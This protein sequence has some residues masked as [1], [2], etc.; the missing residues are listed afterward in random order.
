MIQRKAGISKMNSH[1]TI[2]PLHY[3]ITFF[4]IAMGVAIIWKY[5][6]SPPV[7]ISISASTQKIVE[8]NYSQYAK[9]SYVD[10]GKEQE[11]ICEFRN[12]IA[13]QQTDEIDDPL[14]R[15]LADFLA[16]VLLSKGAGDF[17]RYKQCI[18]LNTRLIPSNDVEYFYQTWFHREPPTVKNAYELAQ[19]MY[20]LE[21]QYN[22]GKHLPVACSFEK[23]AIRMRCIRVHDVNTKI[24]TL[25]GLSEDEL[26]YWFGPIANGSYIF[27]VPDVPI[28]E[29]VK[30]HGS[31]IWVDFQI[32]IKTRDEDM[33][34]LRIRLWYH[35]DMS[36]W[37]IDTVTR[38][39]T[40]KGAMLSPSV[41]SRPSASL[42][43]CGGRR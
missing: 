3:L 43:V 30:N 4:L 32:I 8:D 41:R 31:V 37:I 39:S 40:I 2:K 1:K 42:Q 9:L 22:D 28:E 7:D 21:T 5:K 10:F 38:Q 12:A 6:N 17:D 14:K 11:V 18:Q 33:Y 13:R 16:E 20:T 26:R 34:P 23:A 19:E 24:D 29:A 36:R 25:G 15:T 27:F 35:P